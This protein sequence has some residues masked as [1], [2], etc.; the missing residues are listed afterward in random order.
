MI[1]ERFEQALNLLGQH[2]KDNV[3]MGNLGK[4]G[5]S[6][7]RSSGEK[8]GLSLS[9]LDKNS[10]TVKK[11]EDLGFKVIYPAPLTEKAINE[12]SVGERYVYDAKMN[13]ALVIDGN[14]Q[15]R[16][17]DFARTISQHYFSNGSGMRTGLDTK[18]NSI[19]EYPFGDF[20]EGVSAGYQDLL[21]D[22]GFKTEMNEYGNVTVS[23]DIPYPAVKRSKIEQIY[24]KA[25]GKVQGIFAKL[26][27]LVNSKDKVQENDTNERE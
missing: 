10:D 2:L 4:L 15:N 24:D 14:E 22:L 11:L 13:T 7:D 27:G 19:T 18:N 25:K 6:M 23:S 8:N 20:E 9:K 5:I 26:K 12:M 16:S 1:Q 3:P 21:N 17:L